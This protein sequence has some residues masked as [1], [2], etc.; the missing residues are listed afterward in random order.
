MAHTSNIGGFEH[1]YVRI[2][3]IFAL[4]IVR[5]CKIFEQPFI[6]ALICHFLFSKLWD[7]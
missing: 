6:I 4:S 5:F 3:E 7:V 1:S 2:L